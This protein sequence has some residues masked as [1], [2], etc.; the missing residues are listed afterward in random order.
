M[1]PAKNTFGEVDGGRWRLT[2]VAM[3]KI[4][5]VFPRKKGMSLPFTSIY[6]TSL[7]ESFWR[8]LG[9]EALG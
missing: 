2:F 5:N 6:P 3:L 1:M 7:V 9:F 4:E 8:W